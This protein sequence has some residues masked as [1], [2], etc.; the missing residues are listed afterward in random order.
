MNDINGRKSRELIINLMCNWNTMDNSRK[1]ENSRRSF[2]QRS[3]L[4]TASLAA[5][6]FSLLAG[7]PFAGK[8]D[9]GSRSQEGVPWYRRVTRWG[10][11]NITEKDPTQYDIPWWR[12]F[13]KETGTQGVWLRLIMKIAGCTKRFL[14]F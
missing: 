4:V 8:M 7:P 12:K 10:Q 6:D 3:V 9:H 1:E 11:I 2:L 14:L 5:A 13:W